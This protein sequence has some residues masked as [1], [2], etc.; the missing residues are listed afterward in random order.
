[1]HEDGKTKSK[2]TCR[3]FIMANQMV[4]VSTKNQFDISQHSYII[5]Q[6]LE[7]KSKENFHFQL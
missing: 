5:S 7:L 6:R 2:P 3:L 1:M 4:K